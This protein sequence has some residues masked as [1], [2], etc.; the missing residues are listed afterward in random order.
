[1]IAFEILKNT[2]CRLSPEDWNELWKLIFFQRPLKSQKHRIGRCK[3]EPEERRC[4]ECLPVYQ[5]FRILQKVNDLQ[6]V[7]GDEPK[8]PIHE[9]PGAREALVSALQTVPKLTAKQAAK[10]AGFP[11]EPPSRWKNTKGSI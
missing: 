8:R 5:E 2:T 10:A 11:R 4:E 3:L 9:F 7:Q 1:M 6:V